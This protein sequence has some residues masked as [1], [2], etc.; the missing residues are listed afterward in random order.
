MIVGSWCI[1]W[2]AIISKTVVP[3][4]IVAEQQFNMVMQ[5]YEK[6]HNLAQNMRR[7]VTRIRRKGL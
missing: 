5:I 4:I 1:L 2:Y 3:Q 7:I 6:T